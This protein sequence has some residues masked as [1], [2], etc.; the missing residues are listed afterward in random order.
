MGTPGETA[1][2]EYCAQF[3]RDAGLEVHIQ[4]VAPGR[5]NAVGIL[6]GVGGEE[7]FGANYAALNE[8]G[9]SD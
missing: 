2:V 5:P 1:I 6:R 4:T 7:T 9:I 8:Y 3:M